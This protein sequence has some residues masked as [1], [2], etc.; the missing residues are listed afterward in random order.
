MLN[1]FF[2]LMN[3]GVEND[4]RTIEDYLPKENGDLEELHSIL[5]PPADATYTSLC[6]EQLLHY[7]RESTYADRLEE[8]DPL[9]TYDT[10]VMVLRDNSYTV[11]N[12]TD[13]NALV[14]N[15][16]TGE[17]RWCEKSFSITIDPLV[18]QAT[19]NAIGISSAIYSFAM[20]DNLSN[21]I[22]L[23]D[24]IYLRLQGTLPTSSFVL[25]V[26]YSQKFIRDVN[27]MLSSLENISIPW[28]SADYTTAYLNN[29][30]TLEK[31]AIL[32][33]NLYEKIRDGS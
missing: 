3:R 18:M 32:T 26:Q 19:V 27:T 9:N 8:L 7:I 11:L 23:A 14:L 29:K 22:L 5:V 4:Y 13:M 28:Y 6:T 25:S 15:E 24:K 20:T 2:T 33:M 17:S 30:S 12:N 1:N 10:P 31:V 16:N 21:K